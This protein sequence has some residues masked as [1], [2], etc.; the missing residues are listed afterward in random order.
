VETKKE[1][2]KLSMK[3][4]KEEMLDAYSNV[5]KQLQ[6]KREN[7]MKPEKKLE[8]KKIAETVK[9]AESLTAEGVVRELGSIKIDIGKTLT[10]ISDTLE[11]Q[12]IRLNALQNAIS[13]KEKELH[14]LYEIEKSAMSLAALIEAQNMKRDEFLTEMERKK[15]ELSQ[16]IDKLRAE[17]DKEKE[18]HENTAKE[19]DTAEKKRQLREREEF[20]YAFKKEQQQLKDKAAYENNKLDIEIKSKKEIAEKE[21]KSRE[22]AIAEKEDELID[23]R[24]RA[25]LFPKEMETAINKTV[26]E[27]SE[28]ISLEAKN[29]EELLKKQFEG[30]HNVFKER[31]ESLEKTVKEQNERISV[32]SQQLEA[33]YQKVQDIAVKTVEGSSSFKSLSGIQQLL[34]DQLRKQSAEK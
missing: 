22:Q 25:A 4:T 2:K 29:R 8:G 26:K 30:E 7:E 19:R 5:L 28:K 21:L 16:E 20:E 10:Q 6:E 15:E 23:L 31:T 17:W 18:E 3:S 12:V 11:A 32:L 9:I 33:A 1:A 34:G 27:T 13:S 24:K 14:E